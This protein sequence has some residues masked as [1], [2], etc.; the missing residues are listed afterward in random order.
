MQRII[1]NFRTSGENDNQRIFN[2]LETKCV[3][4]G[5]KETP[6]THEPWPDKVP[7][8]LACCLQRRKAVT[9]TQQHRKHNGNNKLSS[10]SDNATTT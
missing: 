8:K 7:A 4:S 6:R 10:K 3:L 5:Q 9:D 2:Y 1:N